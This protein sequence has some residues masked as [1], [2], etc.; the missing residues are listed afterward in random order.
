MATAR[1]ILS[2]CNTVEL[3]ASTPLRL[4]APAAGRYTVNLFN[5]GPG[6]LYYRFDGDPAV[7]DPGCVTLPANMP[8]NGISI[9][10]TR[11]IGVISDQGTSISIRAAIE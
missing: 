9:D 1:F 2:S 4:V 8:D 3:S 5:L 11:G 6:T 7:G 10:G